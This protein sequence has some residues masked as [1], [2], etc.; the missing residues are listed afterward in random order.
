M[1]LK[2]PFKKEPEVEVLTP[3]QEEIKAL[4]KSLASYAG[5]TEEYGM[6]VHNL[7]GLQDVRRKELENQA[8]EATIPKKENAFIAGLKKIGTTLLDPKVWAAAIPGFFGLFAWFASTK[9]EDEEKLSKPE[10]FKYYD[11]RGFR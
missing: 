10:S 2:N 11:Q 8:L 1:K 5:D 9:R 3:T 4:T 7:D 6:V